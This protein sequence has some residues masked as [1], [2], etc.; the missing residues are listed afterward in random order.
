V[1]GVSKEEWRKMYPSGKF[2]HE[3]VYIEFYFFNFWTLKCIRLGSY[4]KKESDLLFTITTATT[5]LLLLL[6]LLLL[7]VV[8]V[9]VVFTIVAAVVDGLVKLQLYHF[10]PCYFCCFVVLSL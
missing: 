7:V 9:V 5:L 1:E 6:L 3:C 2:V 10:L 4:R 8:V